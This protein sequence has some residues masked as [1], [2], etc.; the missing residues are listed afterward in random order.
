MGTEITEEQ[1]GEFQR[2]VD[3][4]QADFLAMI[5]RGRGMTQSALKPLADGR[6]FLAREAVSLGLIDKVGNWS[7]TRQKSTGNRRARQQQAEQT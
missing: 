1:V 2:L 7:I 6:L 3:G 4:F 5:R